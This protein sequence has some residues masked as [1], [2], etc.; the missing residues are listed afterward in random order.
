MMPLNSAFAFGPTIETMRAGLAAFAAVAGPSW[1]KRLD[2][3]G[4]QLNAMTPADKEKLKRARRW[5]TDREAGRIGTLSDVLAWVGLTGSFI[6]QINEYAQREQ[7]A[8]RPLDLAPMLGVVTMT[9]AG[10]TA[11]DIGKVVAS[12]GSEHSPFSGWRLGVQ[13]GMPTQPIG[14]AYGPEDW[15]RYAVRTIMGFGIQSQLWRL[16]ADRQRDQVWACTHNQP[17]QRTHEAAWAELAEE[18]AA[19]NRPAGRRKD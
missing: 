1:E 12:L 3:T 2:P 19:R 11:N 8:N 15:T 5:W 10:G 7:R 16:D 14:T 9:A 17:R 13:D 18:P 6:G 4:E